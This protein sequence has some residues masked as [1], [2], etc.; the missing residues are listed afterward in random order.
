MGLMSRISASGSL[1][2]TISR[3]GQN[4][5]VVGQHRLDGVLQQPDR[6]A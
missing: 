6:L 3:A 5:P 2:T 4:T 1:W